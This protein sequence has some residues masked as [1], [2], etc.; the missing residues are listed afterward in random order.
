[1]ADKDELEITID[2]EGNVTIKVIGGDGSTCVELT[3]E[4]E[5]ALGL[6]DKRTLTEN[7]YQETQ[8]VDGQ[9]EQQG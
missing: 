8:D 9:V 2:A 1:M 6:V 3:K 4:L 5:E 7:Y